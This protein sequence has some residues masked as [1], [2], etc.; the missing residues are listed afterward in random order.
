MIASNTYCSLPFSSLDIATN[1]NYRICCEIDWTNEEAISMNL[2]KNDNGNPYNVFDKKPSEI[3]NNKEFL[4]IRK[5]MLDNEKPKMCKSCFDREE[6]VKSYSVISRRKRFNRKLNLDSFDINQD[7]KLDVKKINKLFIRMGNLCNLKCRMCNPYSSSPWV[8]DW[9]DMAKKTNM[10]SFSKKMWYLT[11]D[12]KNEL[13]SYDWSSNNLWIKNIEEIAENLQSI[14]F[15][16]GEPTLF[17]EQYKLY[18]MLIEKDCAKNITLL[19]T[20]NL[21]NIPNQCLQ[22]I[23]KFKKVVLNA[24]IDG[25]KDVNRYVRYPTAWSSV[26][27]NLEKY[28]SYKN[29]VLKN[30]CTIQ[31][32]NILHFDK[33]L[34]WIKEKEKNNF[35]FDGV[36][37]NSL[38]SP[39]QLD[40]RV[41]PERLK[42][43][44]YER[45]KP[46]IS[47]PTFFD[48]NIINNKECPVQS[49]VD[50]MHS[51]DLSQHLNHFFAYTTAIDMQRNESLLNIAPEFEPYYTVWKNYVI[52]NKNLMSS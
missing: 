16:G 25:Y 36:F 46:F 24:S 19:M 17:V 12:K 3:F 11:D 10:L 44:A 37:F 1:G 21:T 50:W 9:N 52:K 8:D 40:I 5:Q 28:R 23:D 32:Y 6:N 30:Q 14:E 38:R 34:N 43:L 31:M 47:D 42:N 15:A 7:I 29:V 13:N 33:F 41:L 26:E 22:Y 27:K 51:S 45:L 48:K 20:T 39:V 2:I 35:K 4:S 18:D 49:I